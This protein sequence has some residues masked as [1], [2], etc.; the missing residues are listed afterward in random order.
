MTGRL[1]NRTAGKAVLEADMNDDDFAPGG[2][3]PL[4]RSL[5]TVYLRRKDLA[6]L[7]SELSGG[8]PIDASA[9]LA[10]GALPL[11]GLVYAHEDSIGFY[12]HP[13]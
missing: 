9:S 11:W 5:A 10:Q 1:R 6:A 13:V 4:F 7:A 2:M 3:V 8:D 12:A